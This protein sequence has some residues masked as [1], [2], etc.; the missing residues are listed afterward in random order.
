MFGYMSDK[1]FIRKCEM[2]VYLINR[3]LGVSNE[4]EELGSVRFTFGPTDTS[5]MFPM[6]TWVLQKYSGDGKWETVKVLVTPRK[7]FDKKAV[8]DLLAEIHDT[9]KIFL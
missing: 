4:S 1:E 7:S 3:A 6:N 9:I 8:I 5:A 2:Q